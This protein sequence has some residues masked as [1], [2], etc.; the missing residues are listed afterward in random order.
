MKTNVDQ[1]MPGL[2]KDHWSK[3]LGR[4]IFNLAEELGS[5]RHNEQIQVLIYI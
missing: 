2:K 4:I 5:D 1:S 3:H